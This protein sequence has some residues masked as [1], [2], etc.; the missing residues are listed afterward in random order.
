[1]GDERTVVQ[2]GGEGTLAV[3]GHALTLVSPRFEPPG[4]L[5]CGEEVELIVTVQ[6]PVEEGAQVTFKVKG[7]PDKG[8]RP[9]AADHHSASAPVEKGEA[10]LKWTPNVGAEQLTPRAGLEASAKGA[11]PALSELVPFYAKPEVHLDDGKGGDAPKAVGVSEEVTLR[12]NPEG[13]PKGFFRWSLS[14]GGRALTQVDAAASHKCVLRGQLA[15]EAEDDV[16][17]KV[18]FE[19]EATRKTYDGEHTLTVFEHTLELSLHEL[20]PPEGETESPLAVEP[21]GGGAALAKDAALAGVDVRVLF[22]DDHGLPAA[23]ID[24]KKMLGAT[25]PESKPVNYQGHSWTDAL[26]PKVPV[27]VS[28]ARKLRGGK[29]CAIKAGELKVTLR[30][31]DPAPDLAGQTNVTC[32]AF[33]TA[34]DAALA[35]PKPDRGHNGIKAA[36]GERVTLQTDWIHRRFHTWDGKDDKGAKPVDQESGE[37]AKEENR[38]VLELPASTTESGAHRSDLHLLFQGSLLAGDSYRF[39]AILGTHEAQSGVWTF[40]KRVRCDAL[41]LVTSNPKK[42]S[43]WD[44]TTGL[45]AVVAAYEQSWIDLELPTKDQ[46]YEVSEADWKSTV[47]GILSGKG[48][49][50]KDEEYKHGEFTF[51]DNNLGA[52]DPQP[53]LD[54]LK[55][56]RTKRDA[57]KAKGGG[58]F[59]EWADLQAKKL[60]L[61]QKAH[62]AAPDD[63]AKK[64][65]YE[66]AKKRYDQ[67][68]ASFGKDY[69][70][71]AKIAKDE[72]A[73]YLKATDA[74]DA[75]VRPVRRDVIHALI[76]KGSGGKAKGFSIYLGPQ[77]HRWMG[78]LNGF[79]MGDKEFAFFDKGQGGVEIC[80]TLVHELGHGLYLRH[81]V[82]KAIQRSKQ[83]V[84][85]SGTKVGM[86]LS[87]DPAADVFDH[88]PSHGLKCVMSYTR[89]RSGEQV[90]CGWCQLI[91]RFW[92]RVQLATLGEFRQLLAGRAPG[93][94][95]A[96][97]AYVT[98]KPELQAAPGT[99]AVGKGA[100]LVLLT[101]A[102]D[103]YRVN[104]TS[105]ARWKSSDATK[106]KVDAKGTIK[107]MAA[108]S[109]KVTATL[110]TSKVDLTVAVS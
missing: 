64:K 31:A 33:F 27:R 63:A 84:T 86:C 106:V 87:S 89:D 54:K 76:E 55:E 51:P 95:L 11:A 98:D 96:Q 52:D 107:A 42:G 14:G 75:A 44:K 28:F 57:A 104:L 18:T 78:S 108:G 29:A 8:T 46:T 73:A 82:T 12:A 43:A 26:R 13:M 85:F 83:D 65:A 59:A 94:V 97:A 103:G 88:D 72:Y 20:K 110:G 70:D 22:R 60:A 21:A 19:R 90:F 47:K 92:D 61:L 3:E 41:V 7:F 101:D 91:L 50:T 40:W 24:T 36:G 58:D 30:M 49:A 68:H 81:S 6:G 79:Y 34:L 35:H 109:A 77:L 32:K 100:K 71:N 45:D 93:L 9:S 105:L 16:K 1:M 66:D 48:H 23:D 37:E 56:A 62:L 38:V 17:L 74:V 25:A 67:L 102:I 99:L 10:R 5:V 53:H 2:S 15:S 39:K 80:G 69:L 4:E